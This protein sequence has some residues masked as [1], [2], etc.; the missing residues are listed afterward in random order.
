[1]REYYFSAWTLQDLLDSLM[2]ARALRND[3]TFYLVARLLGKAEAVGT[4]AEAV[5][6]LSE[7]RGLGIGHEWAPDWVVRA[8]EAYEEAPP[9]EYEDEPAL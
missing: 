6:F 2:G 8:Y 7:L 9:E 4:V 5:D 1:M 3:V